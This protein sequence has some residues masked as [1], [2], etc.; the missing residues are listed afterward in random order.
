MPPFASER[1][2]FLF[3]C[4]GKLPWSWKRPE[5]FTNNKVSRGARR[6]RAAG[7]SSV[8]SARVSVVSGLLFLACRDRSVYAHGWIRLRLAAFAPTNSGFS[9]RHSRVELYGRESREFPVNAPAQVS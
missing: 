5:A 1:V 2:V 4:L 9:S 8:V 3:K 7:S 6:C